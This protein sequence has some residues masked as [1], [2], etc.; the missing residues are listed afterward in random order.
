M[1][2]PYD[3]RFSGQAFITLYGE[4]YLNRLLHQR[5]PGMFPQPQSASPVYK[6]KGHTIT[7]QA[8]RYVTCFL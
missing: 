1:P 6:A 2:Y 4:Q 8:V 7:Q 3:V 5:I